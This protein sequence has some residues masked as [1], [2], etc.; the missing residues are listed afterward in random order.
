MPGHPPGQEV[1]LLE[2]EDITFL[3]RQR[4]AHL[5]TADAGGRPAVVPVCFA[6][7][8]A[9]LYVPVDAKPKR[10]DPRRLARLRHLRA[11]PEAVLLVDHYSEDWGALRWLMIR[12]TAQI[13]EAGAERE[14]ALAA[15]EG[16]YPQY[17]AMGL[18]G[19]G[20]PVI[21]LQPTTV[22]RWAAEPGVR[23]G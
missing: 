17:A 15:L 18:A 20:L 19:L 13:L 10:G 3:E 16:R 7:L 12:A 5:A 9:R 23:R 22:R 6:R 4:V 14:A 21:R 2:P 1:A 11:R 8:G